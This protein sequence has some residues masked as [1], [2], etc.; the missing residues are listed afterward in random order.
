MAAPEDAGVDKQGVLRSVSESAQAPKTSTGPL[1]PASLPSAPPAPEGRVW[2]HRH[3]LATLVICVVGLLW[4]AGGLAGGILPATI[5]GA[6]LVL[7]SVVS[8]ILLRFR[9]SA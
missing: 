7:A 5:V 2:G 9:K 4:L 1:T 6:A 8:L 3:I